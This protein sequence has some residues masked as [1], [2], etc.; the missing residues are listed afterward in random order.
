MP[1]NLQAIREYAS[2]LSGNERES[3]IQKFN[4]IKNDDSKVVE[5]SNRI[6]SLSPTKQPRTLKTM[7][8]DTENAIA[9]RPSMMKELI[10]DPTTLERFVKHPLGT[11]LRTVGGAMELA[12]GTMANA[13]I[14]LQQGNLGRIPSDMYKTIT[15]QRPSQLGDIMRNVGTPEPLAASVGL[16][17]SGSKF[18]P[19]TQINNVAL[20]YSGATKLGEMIQ[21]VGKPA[22]ARSL[23]IFSGIE[24]NKMMDALN[25]PKMLS[26]SFLKKE[27]KNVQALYKKVVDPVIQDSSKR[28]DVSK[29]IDFPKEFGLYTKSGEASK[30]LNSMTKMEKS[31]IFS[32]RKAVLKKDLSFNEVDSLIGQMDESLSSVYRKEAAGKPVDFSDDFLR[33]TR[34][35]R[36]KL[37]GIR[38]S[39][40]PEVGK[41][42][43][44]YE[45][46]K[47]GET[48]Y[49]H[50]DRWL[51][52]LMPSIVLGA[53]SGVGAAAG[54][55][56]PTLS[57]LSILGAIPKVQGLGIRAGANIANE[58]GKSGSIPAQALFDM[59]RKSK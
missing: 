49:K 41:V 37:N 20:K 54:H 32:W 19:T 21:K 45:K 34:Q 56:N 2:S 50:F 4:S 52:H 8:D 6:S 55:F 12:E 23:S 3:F 51:P 28:V 13:G 43:D 59:W 1:A 48:L 14:A 18:S 57:G 30:V 35:L 44:Q 47:A 22:L 7:A 16:L 58:I 40:Y 53:L 5:L 17:A 46:L 9:S 11:T 38:K 31:K 42:L 25:N 36:S 24:K 10:K 15:G 29:A 39:Q 26:S 27:N 33:V